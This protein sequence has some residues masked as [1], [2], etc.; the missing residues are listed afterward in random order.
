MYCGRNLTGSGTIAYI[1]NQ[2]AQDLV[3]QEISN[4][5]LN[6]VWINGFRNV[7]RWHWYSR[8]PLT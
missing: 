3:Q 2:F 7:R 1:D 5:D 8:K 6:T 4:K